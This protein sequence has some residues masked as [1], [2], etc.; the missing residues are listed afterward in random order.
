MNKILIV[1]ICDTLYNSNTTFDFLNFYYSDNPNYKRL[2][3]LRKNIFVKGFNKVFYKVL[4]KDL[5]RIIFTFFLKNEKVKDI[6]I[7]VENFYNNFLK[8]REKEISLN[9]LKKY[10]LEG[11]DL[12]IISGTYQFIAKKIGKKLKITKVYGTLLEEKKGKYSGRLKL[13][14]LIYKEKIIRE[15]LNE[16]SNSILHLLTDNITDYNLVK[17]TEKANIVIT[18]YN[19][20]FWI[21]KKEVKKIYFLQERNKD[22]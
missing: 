22:V 18:D 16:N 10:K 15:I 9:L 8:S 19:K 14:M 3:K 11:Y 5:V 21:S 2:N 1:D 13:D 12:V 17:Y 20:N 4:K 7:A 6:E